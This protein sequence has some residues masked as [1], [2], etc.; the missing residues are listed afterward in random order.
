MAEKLAQCLFDDIEHELITDSSQ[1]AVFSFRGNDDL[2]F[3]RTLNAGTL[4]S[5]RPPFIDVLR[6]CAGRRNHHPEKVRSPGAPYVR[7]RV[8]M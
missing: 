8:P 1:Q 4:K 6:S 5:N 7:T 3:L 2:I